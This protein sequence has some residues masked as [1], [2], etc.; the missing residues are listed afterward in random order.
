[1][2]DYCPAKMILRQKE[3]ASEKA[4]AQQKDI[5]KQSRGQA[6]REK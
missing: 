3:T 4:V 2:P 1:M 6:E 5:R